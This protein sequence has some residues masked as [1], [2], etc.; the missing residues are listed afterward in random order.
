MWVLYQQEP[1]VSFYD[2]QDWLHLD[3]L[4]SIGGP[5][6]D[7]EIDQRGY[8]WFASDQGIRVWDGV[9]MRV[10]TPPSTM[11]TNGFRTML[12]EDSDMW[13][14]TTRGLLR[15]RQ[16]QWQWVL[17]GIVI[18]SIQSDR[19]GGLLLGTDIG[20]MRF[21]GSQSYLWVINLGTETVPGPHVSSTAWDG[22]GQLWVGT[23]GDGLY[24]FDGVRWEKFD[25]SYG[26]PT[27][28]I[29]TVYADSL[30]ELWITAVT[31]GGGALIRYMP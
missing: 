5:I 27:D 12:S 26:L 16:S 6:V 22:S 3:D 31:D 11:P 30:G 8:I 20:L 1:Q 19:T 15:Y 9:V 13:V 18:N 7:A 10:Y 24:K 4:Q 25:T 14:G 17:P 2:G 29:R 28:N 21:D 23:I